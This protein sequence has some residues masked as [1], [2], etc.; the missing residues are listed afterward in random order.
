MRS[1]LYLN[2]ILVLLMGATGA[3]EPL[4]P[5]ELVI[6]E[7]TLACIG[8]HWPYSGG[9]EH[10]AV[11][12]RYR[13]TSSG[14]WRQ[15]L[16]PIAT[17]H[18]QLGLLFAGSIFQLEPGTDYEVE[19][20]V[21][22]PDGVTGEAV[23]R[24][25]VRTRAVPRMPTGGTTWHVYPPGYSGEREQ[26]QLPSLLDATSGPAVERIAPG[27]HIVLHAGTHTVTRPEVERVSRAVEH[28]AE[29][30]SKATL[31]GRVYHLYP[32]K[33]G[34]KRP[35]KDGEL[36][37]GSPFY[38]FSQFLYNEELVDFAPGDTILVHAGTYKPNRC[39]YRE[40]L[41]SCCFWHGTYFMRMRGEP[42]RPIK[43][44]A[45]GDGEVIFDGDGN[46]TLFD[47]L[48]A[49][50]LW[51]DGITIQN[52]AVAFR[53]GREGLDQSDGL[54]ITDCQV[55]DVVAPVW[56]QTH[57]ENHEKPWH[58]NQHVRLRGTAERPIVIRS[59][60]DGAVV[61]DGQGAF[62]LFDLLEA[63]HLWFD[64]L[65]IGNAEVA[66]WAGR[67]D[68]AG[69][70]GLLVTHCTIEEARIGV[71]GLNADSGRY[72]IADNTFV[73]S[74]RGRHSMGNYE[75]PYGVLLYGKGHIVTHNRVEGFHDGI[76]AGWW[77][78][79]ADFA[80]D[81]YCASMDIS[82]NDLFYCGDNFIETDGGTFNIRVLH[83]R[84]FSCQSSGLSNQSPR[85][86]PYYWIR[87]IAFDSKNFEDAFKHTMSK[88]VRAYHN[89]LCNV[90]KRRLG[91]DIDYRNNLFVTT[92]TLGKGGKA[93]PVMEINPACM[94]AHDYNAYAVPP[95]SAEIAFKAGK[96]TFSSL[97]AFAAAAGTSAHSVIV[98]GFD[99]FQH[100]P[101]PSDG[102]GRS[103]H[104]GG[105]VFH[106]EGYDFRLREN[107]AAIDAAQ[108][109]PNINDDFSGAA[110]DIGAIEYGDPMPHYG[111]R[112][113]LAR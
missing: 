110:P 101:D 15:A 102:T 48:E 51:F 40:P 7:P 61:I 99:C 55:R 36:L 112:S 27:D 67:W 106:P 34:K 82:H 17:S 84:M 38:Q 90:D 5:G 95:L 111:P 97:E 52:T 57:M 75:S 77:Y 53:A 93:R 29:L 69:C 20:T 83:N 4:V 81:R 11:A 16:P 3:S 73:G 91:R 92:N 28:Q 62:R 86:G 33:R 23:H 64:G 63:D 108:R 25:T 100:V 105:E 60:G 76:D 19:W 56:Q 13:S 47:C 8:Y 46:Y 103:E 41:G 26:P 68:Q 104:K 96:Q 94:T 113:S 43:I 65:T 88:H 44:Q 109:L 9:G 39:N 31:D 12:V 1:R 85:S 42:G 78:G 30:A 107:C 66:F 35:G 58:G 74:Q 79:N 6:E 80:K 21:Q 37:L 32:P 14:D 72:Y 22:D 71:F 10:A 87:N 89:T 50:H 70:D 98:S 49:D 18:E 24:A 59:A 45:A 2:A 54:I